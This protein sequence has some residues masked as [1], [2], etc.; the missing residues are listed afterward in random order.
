MGAVGDDVRAVEGM[1]GREGK[2]IGMDV[3]PWNPETGK[4]SE[5]PLARPF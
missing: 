4:V 3:Y 5:K 1:E 2:V